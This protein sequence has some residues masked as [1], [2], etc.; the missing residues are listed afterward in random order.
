MEV[1][2]NLRAWFVKA[3]RRRVHNVTNVPNFQQKFE[4]TGARFLS[5]IHTDAHKL[6]KQRRPTEIHTLIQH[7]PAPSNTIPPSHLTERGERG[8]GSHKQI[9]SLHSVKP[10]GIRAPFSVLLLSNPGTKQQDGTVTKLLVTATEL[11]LRPA[12]SSSAQ[13]HS[14]T[15]WPLHPGLVFI[16]L[17]PG[18]VEGHCRSHPRI[19]T[20]THSHGTTTC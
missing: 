9:A 18:K 6:F 16:L 2:I 17:F 11:Q 3:F 14:D 5:G 7:T 13:S 12:G 1:R 19:N 10:R 20:Y 4:K 8:I 15:W